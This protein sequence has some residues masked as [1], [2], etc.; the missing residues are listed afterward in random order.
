M[1]QKW[2]STVSVTAFPRRVLPLVSAT[3][4]ISLS[5]LVAS[6]RAADQFGQVTE[7]TPT[8]G[9]AHTVSTTLKLKA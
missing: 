3:L 9:T 7:Y 5:L 8:G 6:A 4:S 2:G 1:V